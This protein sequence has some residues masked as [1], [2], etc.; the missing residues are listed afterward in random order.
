MDLT[1]LIKSAAIQALSSKSCIDFVNGTIE[2]FKLDDIEEPILIRVNQKLVLNK[3]NLFFTETAFNKIKKDD[4]VILSRTN[5]GQKY[6]V[7]DRVIKL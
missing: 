2:K 6:I 1:E 4:S 7:I 5:D 3:T